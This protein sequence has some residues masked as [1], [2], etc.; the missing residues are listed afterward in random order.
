MG[1]RLARNRVVG[2][3]VQAQLFHL[4]TSHGVAHPTYNYLRPYD[5]SILPWDSPDGGRYSDASAWTVLGFDVGFPIGIPASVLTANADW[6]HFYASRGF[7]VLTFKTARTE[8]RVPHPPPNWLFVD[9]FD[10]AIDPENLEKGLTVEASQTSWPTNPDAF[11][12]VNSFGVPSLLP[13]YWMEQ[14]DRSVRELG[15]GKLLIASVVGNERLSTFQETVEDY[16]RAAQMAEGCGAKAIELNLSCPN[17]MRD[18]QVQTDLIASDPDAAAAVVQAVRKALKSDTR[19]IAKLSYLPRTK[20][21]SVLDRIHG[22]L[23]GVSG[24]NT[25]QVSVRDKGENAFP[26]RAVA[27]LSGVAIRELGFEFARNVISVRGSLGRSESDFSV[28]SMGGVMNAD[29]VEAYRRIGACAVQ[30]A[31]A[32]FFNAELARDVINRYGA[33]GRAHWNDH[34]EEEALLALENG[35]RQLNDLLENLSEALQPTTF[36]LASRLQAVLSGLERKHLVRSFYQN[37][38]VVFER[39]QRDESSTVEAESA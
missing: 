38:R 28:I 6:I 5:Y 4:L 37:G 27:G 34:V 13:Q 11:S 23:N 12:M 7:N 33:L 17:T 15:P 19:L 25:L 18:G 30:T 39:T 31:T 26:R 10:R 8:K 24:I 36:E 14:L 21:E 16:A 32:A 1:V 22:S 3:C 2:I 35:P 29:D 9:G 20:L